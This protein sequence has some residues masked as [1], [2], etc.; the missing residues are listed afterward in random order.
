MKRI[1]GILQVERRTAARHHVRIR[2][3]YVV[4]GCA[5]DATTIDISE[6]GMCLQTGVPL[7]VGTTIFLHLVPR[8]SLDTPRIESTVMWVRPAGKGHEDLF[9]CGLRF[10][11]M[12]PATLAQVREIMALRAADA[13][14]DEIPEL[15]AAEVVEVEAP[16]TPDVMH[17]A[18]GRD[19]EQRHKDMRYAHKLLHKGKEA[20]ARAD[21]EAATILLEQAVEQMPD[22]AEA[23]EELARVVYLQGDVIKAAQLFDRALRVRQE[24]A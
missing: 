5:L 24:Q 2:V 1:A 3:L 9:Q 8:E 10:A 4:S 11:P 15:D 22:S 18:L 21:L 14:S 20:A 17:A 6:T 7:E 23:I 12:E 19:Q 16:P 13:A